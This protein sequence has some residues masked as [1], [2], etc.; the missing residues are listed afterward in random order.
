MN[1]AAVVLPRGMAC[2]GIFLLF[3]P[4]AKYKMAPEEVSQWRIRISVEWESSVI[5]NPPQALRSF[6]P[7]RKCFCPSAAGCSE[8]L[9][10]FHP[11]RCSEPGWT[12]TW[13]SWSGVTAGSAWAGGQTMSLAFWF[14]VYLKELS[15]TVFFYCVRGMDVLGLFGSCS[16]VMQGRLKRLL[17]QGL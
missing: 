7:V 4:H 10:R 5:I 14:V 12:K 3:T 11:W 8:V 1:T 6:S 16:C 17:A 9:C 13:T 15:V 2:V